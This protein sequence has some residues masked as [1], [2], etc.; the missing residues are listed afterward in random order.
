MIDPNFWYVYRYD[1]GGWL[2]CRGKD[3]FWYAYTYDVNGRILT[4]RDSSGCQENYIYGDD[5]NCTITRTQEA[6]TWA[7]GAAEAAEVADVWANF[8]PCGLLERLIKID[9]NAQGAP[10]AE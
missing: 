3:G 4:Y 8:D 9:N 6:A 7:A 10:H 5:D 2:S 1:D